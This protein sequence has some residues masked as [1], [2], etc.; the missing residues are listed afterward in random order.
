M[1]R[2]CA[3]E[4]AQTK[5]FSFPTICAGG[6]AFAACTDDASSESRGLS[7]RRV[8]FGHHLGARPTSG[9]RRLCADLSLWPTASGRAS[10]HTSEL[11]S[12][13]HLVCRLLL[14]K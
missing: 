13:R 12:L 2:G 9:L 6:I 5:G 8:G 10:E 1:G 7:K 3:G 11:Q 14:E 4:G